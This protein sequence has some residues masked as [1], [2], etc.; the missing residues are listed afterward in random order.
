M[1]F[2]P[3]TPK[4]SRLTS[5]TVDLFFSA[6]ICNSRAGETTAEVPITRKSSARALAVRAVVIA[7]FDVA[8][9]KASPSTV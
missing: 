5:I 2:K 6:I 9:S 3:Q 1:R 4:C 8:E 7:A